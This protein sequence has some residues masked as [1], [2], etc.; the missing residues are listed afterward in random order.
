MDWDVTAAGRR[1]LALADDLQTK[2]SEALASTE[3]G[4]AQTASRSW[5]DVDAAMARAQEVAGQLSDRYSPVPGV[6]ASPVPLAIGIARKELP[7][8]A[9]TAHQD[10]QQGGF[11]RVVDHARS[12]VHQVNVGSGQVVKPMVEQVLTPPRESGHALNAVL[13]G[14]WKAAGEH[15]LRAVAADAAVVAPPQAAFVQAAKDAHDKGAG[16]VG[17]IAAGT[18]AGNSAGVDVVNGMNPF[19]LFP[20]AGE[21][22]HQ[23]VRSLLLDRDPEG[24]GRNATGG[25][26]HG[27][28][29]IGSL[30]DVANA[31][32]LPGRLGLRATTLESGLAD[33]F[34][35][36]GGTGPVLRSPSTG[37][38]RD[39]LPIEPGAVAG[40]R[41]PPGPLPPEVPIG[42]DGLP[43]IN[44]RLPINGA[45]FAGKRYFDK[46]PADLK[47]K[48]PEGV[49]FKAN[50]M[51]DFTP[52]ATKSVEVDGLVGD[53]YKD[54]KLANEA[55]GLERYGADP[56][57]GF[58]W[59]HCEDGR[60]MQL[61]PDD[62]HG[63]VKHTGGEAVMEHLRREAAQ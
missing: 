47:I 3:H 31:A 35:R 25:V 63:A 59:H 30:F 61:V 26:V 8:V 46:L 19:Y 52:Y 56:P 57:L 4:V 10:F 40:A 32:A 41:K 39:P 36:P 28:Q 43:R 16:L 27:G 22:G 62:I 14:Q 12:F 29:A 50:G 9:A 44:G 24:F 33:G 1:A 34:N 23:A 58:T 20:I 49:M 11:G 60:T 53:T 17:S 18:R 38:L 21:D 2:A 5:A 6:P 48:Y 13:H 55:A 37:A 7:K 54:Y 51:P 42:P 15:E 45:E